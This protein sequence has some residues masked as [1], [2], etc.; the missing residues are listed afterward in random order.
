MHNDEKE[1]SNSSVNKILKKLK[2]EIKPMSIFNSKFKKNDSISS[3]SESDLMTPSFG[4]CKYI[5]AIF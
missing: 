2:D 5:L 4:L 3:I 1:T